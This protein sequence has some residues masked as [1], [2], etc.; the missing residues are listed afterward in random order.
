MPR[1]GLGHK[2]TLR[3]AKESSY[4]VAATTATAKYDVVNFSIDPNQSV[5]EDPNVNTD[6]GSPRDILQG[7][8]FYTGSF[9]IALGYEGFEEMLRFLMPT[10][11]S[12]VVDTV[13][14]HTYKEINDAPGYTFEHSMGDIPTGKVTRLLGVLCTGYRFNIQGAQGD[15]GLLILDVD[16]AAATL[17]DD[18]TGMG[19]TPTVDN[20]LKVP[21][22]QLDR[23]LSAGDLLDGSGL[24]ENVIFP[25]GLSLDASFPHEPQRQYLGSVN[26]DSPV[27]NGPY[28][29]RI[30]VDY[31]W[32]SDNW[33]LVDKMFQNTIDSGGLKFLFRHGTGIGGSSFREI[34]ITAANP[35]PAGA[36]REV[37]GP[38]AIT[39]RT[40]FVCAFDA[41]ALSAVVIRNRSNTVAL[42]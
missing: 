17:A 41:T 42:T 40:S 23:T 11:S 25:R 27:R 1:P 29:F 37:P 31:E 28:S 16:F 10:Y 20:I 38:G 33:P 22:H 36:P 7:L 3:I 21:F 8:Q 32:D 24:A 26:A 34:E 14:D 5:M 6:G 18:Q 12:A 4:G 9:R 13:V 35:T 39:F 15:G 30:E 19:G 2:S